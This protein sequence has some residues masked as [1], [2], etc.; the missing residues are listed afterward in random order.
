M[1]LL[2]NLANTKWCKNPKKWLKPWHMG[3]HLRVFSESYQIN[4]NMTGF[5][6]F[7]K[8]CALEESSLHI[9]GVKILLA[10]KHFAKLF[11][12][13]FKPIHSFENNFEVKHHLQTI[14][15]RVVD[16]VL[17]NNFSSNIFQPMLLLKRYHQNSQVVLAATGMKGLN[18]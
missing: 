16:K 7:S 10:N 8:Y 12:L 14:L 6:W 4:T 18:S 1:L 13:R 3:T 17:M 5:R 9:G 2:A 11:I 15:S